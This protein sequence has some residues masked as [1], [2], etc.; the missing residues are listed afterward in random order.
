M[1]R[2][3][4]AFFSLFIGSTLLATSAR[5]ELAGRWA[6]GE[7][8]SLATIQFDFQDGD[9]Y[10]FDVSFSGD[11]FTGQDVFVLLDAEDSLF[12]FDYEVISYSFGD[13]LTGVGIEDSY[14][15]G[16]GS[17]APDYV[18]YWHY[19]TR[20][21]SDLEW[22]SSMIGFGSR[23]LTDGAEDAWVFG[24]NAAPSLVPV[25]GTVAMLAGG[26]ILRRRR[27]RVSS[28]NQV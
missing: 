15:Y 23:I 19:W 24:S 11:S 9:T 13:F 17:E 4:S 2:L 26:L 20:D 7:G 1:P 12:D 8:D 5:A 27:C 10:L 3:S 16:D 22:S 14:D 6:I 18:N 28:A 25:P 21:S